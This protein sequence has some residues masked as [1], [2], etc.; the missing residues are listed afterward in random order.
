M[1]VVGG[2]PGEWRIHFRRQFGL[3]E[4]VEWDN[5]DTGSSL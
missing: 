3:A 4:T 5:R 2:V 1:R